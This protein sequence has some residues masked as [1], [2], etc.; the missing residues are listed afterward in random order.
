MAALAGW[1]R[2]GV[3]GR[4]PVAQLIHCQLIFAF[5]MTSS[6]RHCS[7]CLSSHRQQTGASRAASYL[8]ALA[9]G[10]QLIG[11]GSATRLSGSRRPS[12]SVIHQHHSCG[13]GEL[14]QQPAARIHI[15]PSATVEWT[16]A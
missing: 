10:G 2:R 3:S 12:R 5:M 9:D 6:R 14:N 13:S 16:D 4:C 15:D 1:L 11:L 7:R 8:I